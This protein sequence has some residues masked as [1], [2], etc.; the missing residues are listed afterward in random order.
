MKTPRAVTNALRFT[1]ERQKYV[2]PALFVALLVA[3][4]GLAIALGPLGVYSNGN[5]VNFGAPTNHPVGAF[6]DTDHKGISDVQQLLQCGVS[7]YLNSTARDGIPDVW[8]CKHLH[9]DSVSG[10]YDP[11]I[12]SADPMHSGL[13]NLEKYQN[14]SK[15][16]CLSPWNWS[17]AGNQFPDG[18]LVKSGLSPCK[19]EP[20][21][22]SFS[23]DNMTLAKK[24]SLGLNATAADSAHNGLTDAQ[25]I[26]GIRLPN[27]ATVY[28]NPRVA[29]TCDNTIS[30]GWLVAF[31][32]DP[33]NCTVAYRDLGGSGMTTLEKW[34]Y[35]VH[36]AASKGINFSDPGT[37]PQLRMKEY[38]KYSLDPTVMSTLND[39]ISDG[40][41]VR[42]GL[43]PLDPGVAS[44]DQTGGGLTNLQKFLN[45]CDPNKIS[46]TGSI[47]SDYTK[48]TGI[49]PATGKVRLITLA[50]GTTR[51]WHA[52][53]DRTDSSGSGISDEQKWV[54]FQW[55][56]DEHYCAA[57]PCP[58]DPMT[59]DTAFSG[60][61]D[62]MKSTLV[63]GGR[64]L[65]P[66]ARDTDG[67]HMSDGEKWVYW[68]NRSQN[69]TQAQIDMIAAQHGVPVSEV[70]QLLLP[71]SSL[72][73][74]GLPNILNK[75]VSNSGI[76]NGDK[77]HPPPLLDP[78]SH[79][80]MS[81]PA[82]DPA[83]VSTGGS[84]LPDGWER[85][86]DVYDGV[87]HHWVLDPTKSNSY[88]SGC[89]PGT[90]TA[91]QAAAG[92]ADRND[93]DNGV[94]YGAG[95]AHPVSFAF[96]NSQKWSACLQLNPGKVN[97]VDHGYANCPN[98][99]KFSTDG[100]GI[101]DGWEFY[102]YPWLQENAGLPVTPLNPASAQVVSKTYPYTIFRYSAN[103]TNLLAMAQAN[104][105]IDKAACAPDG[106]NAIIAG[107]PY[108]CRGPSGTGFVAGFNGTFKLRLIDE[109]NNNTDP[110]YPSSD[111]QIG[112]ERGIAPDAWLL[113]WKQQSC[114]S[115]TAPTCG[116][117]S[118]FNP[119]DPN[120]T[121][122]VIDP[123]E[124]GMSEA[125]DYHWG[126]N[127]LMQ[128]S[129][130]G[131][132]NDVTE[133]TS[134]PEV[135]GILDPKD[136]NPNQ[137]IDNSHLTIAQKLDTSAPWAKTTNCVV[138]RICLTVGSPSSQNTG[139]LDGPDWSLTLPANASIVDDL[140]N[141]SIVPEPGSAHFDAE[142][143][144]TSSTITFAG[145]LNPDF[146]IKG[147]GY[148]PTN[149]NGTGDGIPAGWKVLYGL[150]V[151][152]PETTTAS[153]TPN[154]TDAQKYLIGMPSNWS[155]PKNGPW[156][157]GANPNAYDSS[158]A[159]TGDGVIDPLTGFA[160]GGHNFDY[161]SNGLNDFIGE[162]PTPFYDHNTTGN[163]S[164][165]NPNFVRSWIYGGRLAARDM[166]TYDPVDPIQNVPIPDRADYIHASVIVTNITS[167]AGPGSISK[168]ASA[169]LEGRVTAVT[170]SG[171]TVGV[172]GI[173]VVAN[174]DNY[175]KIQYNAVPDS[176]HVLGI[177][178]TD[179]L[180]NFAI[181]ASLTSTHSV[182]LGK[183]V[184][185]TGTISK[186]VVF[187]HVRDLTQPITWTTT[188]SLYPPGQAYDWVVW[189]YGV[190]PWEINQ[191]GMHHFNYQ[192][193]CASQPL[194]QCPNGAFIAHGVNGTFFQPW[195]DA[196]FGGG[197]GN[198]RG[199]VKTPTSIQFAPLASV[200]NNGTFTTQ[201][202]VVDATQDPLGNI[203]VTLQWFGQTKH[204]TS[205]STGAFSASF[206]V[207]FFAHP[208]Q[209]TLNAT[210][211][212]SINAITVG[213]VSHETVIVRFPT[214]LHGNVTNADLT[215]FAG[216]QVTV[217]ARLLDASGGAVPN[218]LVTLSMPDLALSGC[219]TTNRTGDV[220]LNVTL[221]T[222]SLV[223]DFAT[224]ISYAQTPAFGA[225][226]ASLQLVKVE[227]RS[228][229]QLDPVAPQLNQTLTITGT[230]TDAAGR[231][232][233]DPNPGFHP[234]I[235]LDTKG[236][237]GQTNVT[238]SKWSMTIPS[239]VFHTLESRSFRFIF[240]GSDFY[241]PAESDANP[242]IVTSSAITVSTTHFIRGTLPAAHGRMVDNLGDG[243]AN[244]RVNVS[245]GPWNASAVTASDGS[246][247]AFLPIPL[248]ATAQ[249]YPLVATYGGDRFHL[250]GSTPVEGAT[251]LAGTHIVTAPISVPTGIFQLNATLLDDQ[252]NP[253]G[254]ATLGFHLLAP[255]DPT[256]SSITDGRGNAIAFLSGPIVGPGQYDLNVTYAAA[257]DPTRA[258]SVAHELVTVLARTTLTF[259]TSTVAIRGEDI[260]IHGSLTDVGGPGVGLARIDAY[261]NGTKVGSFFTDDN[262]NFT[263]S[264]SIPL[265]FPRTTHPL[266]LTYDGDVQHLSSRAIQRVAVVGLT[267]I[268]VKV[269]GSLQV[270]QAFTAEIELHDD[271]GNPVPNRDVLV[272]LPGYNE[273]F[274]VQTNDTGIA[275]LPGRVNALGTSQ[276]S[277]QFPGEGDLSAASETSEIN[278][279]AAGVV[280][281]G[282]VA[283]LVVVL[284]LLA[285]SIASL[286]LARFR[287]RQI[288]KARAI[289][290]AAERALLAGNEYVATI[291][292]AYAQLT[293]HF[294]KFGYV[295]S[296]NVTPQEFAQ[297][298]RTALPVR[299][300]PL[301]TLV[302]L[303]EL[304][305]YS[306]HPVGPAE[307]DAA[308][309]AL[310]ALNR[311]LARA[312]RDRNV[313]RGPRAQEEPA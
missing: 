4:V 288:R 59:T 169:I 232:I 184:T 220:L 310:A 311:D 126:T 94:N 268:Q 139:L 223:G 103:L 23:P 56:V 193:L 90:M 262:G 37:A 8:K 74:C 285:L 287:R 168:G 274:I 269:S 87:C 25:E 99:E 200:T 96:N 292:H 3:G 222:D 70:R 236:F 209:G 133:L 298:A 14:S 265:N 247:V 295:P 107:H 255:G 234:V 82:T 206:N 33:T 153:A 58:L 141:H 176:G 20:P 157:L 299:D 135:P 306:D 286:M 226:T 69:S 134:T 112:E 251:V 30:D 85:T 161:N 280:P 98:P 109:F 39:G 122:S 127:P 258:P 113:F 34:Q 154:I 88:A 115:K 29:S 207:G 22:V 66:L 45:N 89:H 230:L 199:Y 164:P 95:Y 301:A 125:D 178:I 186:A 246:F 72:C 212:T 145:S 116:I 261:L 313:R 235:F 124:K 64:H 192:T 83:L 252:G 51:E 277:V 79:Q 68:I 170:S 263:A 240:D 194:A 5:A 291:L 190:G 248:N 229:I 92:D 121:R 167:T 156:F 162:D 213:S 24:Y 214:A 160:T 231:A 12:A 189:S 101:A 151:N 119:V 225:S 10:S 224:T 123:I 228:T 305:R 289:L 182:L 290:G 196:N 149:W 278:V 155:V 284:A 159:G 187:G 80:N 179:A 242:D 93:V 142:G 270:G 249:S 106:P 21:N 57:L 312:E 63:L 6:V 16:P 191:P 293:E 11:I 18:Y 97:W 52:R 158:G 281:E 31:G 309:A 44:R 53:C 259:N 55:M 300:E 166:A 303:F 180:G 297:A 137:D 65:N 152:F 128:D 171:Q 267:I 215:A 173:I 253:V 35:S 118:D 203:P 86:F 42:Y 272:R 146:T 17:S 273:T 241:S 172:P 302:R 271:A 140:F 78:I 138:N 216:Q 38:L 181:N 61:S 117:G 282:Q 254:G 100:T 250:P 237:A 308:I 7:P 275:T 77:V 27:G 60:L 174:Y 47:L 211:D 177:G 40:W 110:R 175:S 202:T 48:I 256:N 108:V 36:Y 238:G 233:Q 46:T 41:K 165:Y 2:L 144:L 205:S 276:V 188:T 28:P 9:Y 91:A 257:D 54:G 217:H 84:G 32:L 279:A 114:L 49:D 150:P 143:H 15:Y 13:T 26:A 264:L 296:S 71:T 136:D 73:G 43:D 102:F 197:Y 244:M 245:V 76:L 185:P 201:G 67:D 81:F 148:D 131:G 120:L 260:L 147:A 210:I 221:P 208:F 243:I 304:A 204:V 239:L 111:G 130:F 62:Y 198:G 132:V 105:T 294:V 218:A 195:T 1:L 163:V 50:D 219:G 266:L 227:Q 104:E 307:R 19:Y 129:D 75:D 183:V 283:A